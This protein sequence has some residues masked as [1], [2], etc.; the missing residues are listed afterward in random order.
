MNFVTKVSANLRGRWLKLIEPSPTIEEETYRWQVRSF[1][2]LLIPAILSVLCG[3]VRVML[4]GTN[5]P[6][7]LFLSGTTLLLFIAYGFGRT[8][9]YYM[10]MLLTLIVLSLPSFIFTIFSNDTIDTQVTNRLMWLLMPLL[11]GGLWLSRLRLIILLIIEIGGVLLLGLFIPFYLLPISL[12]YIGS[13]SI[14]ILIATTIREQY[15][16]QIKV[17]SQRALENE[18]R[19]RSLFEATFEGLVVHKDGIIWDANPAFESLFGY[20]LSEIKGQS[21]LNLIE[22]TEK[23]V[24]ETYLQT[25][26]DESPLETIGLKKNGAQ[27]HLELLSKSHI[28]QEQVLQITALRDI[29]QHKQRKLVLEYAKE[30]AEA[31]N[32]AKSLFITNMSHELRTPLNGIL[33]YTQILERDKTLT[34]QQK[35]G[36]TVIH[37]SGQH[38]LTLLND[39]LDISK[40]EAGKMVL[41]MAPFSLD[42]FLALI[43]S[44]FSVKAQE[45]GIRFEYSK[46]T[47]LPKIIIGDE[48]RLRQVLINLLSNALKFTLMGQVTFRVEYAEAGQLHNN[49]QTKTTSVLNQTIHFEVIDT[50]IGI[51]TEDINKI[52]D[53]FYQIPSQQQ[54]KVEGTGLGLSIS[55]R[56][57]DLMGSKLQV[58][59]E[60]GT[61]SAFYFDLTLPVI[62]QN[63]KESQSTSTP[64]IGFMGVHKKVLVVDDNP[65]NRSMY[66]NLLTPLGFTVFEAGNGE[67]ALV[68]TQA[69]LPDLILMDLAM[70]APNGIETIK[71]IRRWE[72]EKKTQ[73]HLEANYKLTI[74]AIS[75]SVF[76]KDQQKSLGAGCDSF[77]SKPFQLAALLQHI[78]THL[79]LIWLYKVAVDTPAPQPEP[80]ALP[81]VLPPVEEMIALF[82][83]VYTGHFRVIKDELQRL[84][85]LDEQYQPFIE[86][87]NKLAKQYKI[88]Q[89]KEALEIHYQTTNWLDL[90]K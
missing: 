24:M 62:Q 38:L 57:L 51:S 71:Q 34:P 76:E 16:T 12:G 6:V 83:A 22:P 19:F 50:G 5:M 64:V 55:K 25:S 30:Q 8:K 18:A 90:E 28:Y 26:D 59:S 49:Q 31:A 53:P 7:F 15:Q 65:H 44:I 27:V 78:Q 69:V 35:H 58:K 85:A 17:Q 48:K 66:A 68:E 54:S 33:G 61:G 87:L 89:L 82:R 60:P 73:G 79:N 32:K 4:L 40:V 39:I 14:L 37:Q 13:M 20:N 81:L 21:I 23:T 1:L 29:T 67:N 63:V 72:R 56:L 52:F 11:L 75:E 9:Y 3:T 86:Q 77:L 47:T 74:I 45:Q 41:Q 10:G 88:R 70:P 36:I 42:P 84:Q 43:V 46:S 2:G 80:N